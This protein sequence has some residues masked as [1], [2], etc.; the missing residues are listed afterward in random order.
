[1]SSH[2]QSSFN[3]IEAEKRLLDIEHRKKQLEFNQR[4]QEINRN[5]ALLQLRL[6]KKHKA[7]HTQQQPSR[8]H[9][10]LQTELQQSPSPQSLPQSSPQHAGPSAPHTTWVR[11]TE[12]Q[13]MVKESGIDDPK[14]KRKALALLINLRTSNPTRK[15]HNIREYARQLAL[16]PRENFD[17]GTRDHLKNI[18][19]MVSLYSTRKGVF[20]KNA[21]LSKYIEEH[22]K[23]HLSERAFAAIEKRRERSKKYGGPGA[24][25]TIAQQSTSA[26][27]DVPRA[28]TPASPTT[29]STTNQRAAR[30]LSSFLG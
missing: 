1:M 7:S 11:T 5:E 19:K 29:S 23:K 26:A 4:K 16:D 18:E 24:S 3:S 28:S 20:M 9:S 21:T 12:F 13:D 30:I 8:Q 25:A 15:L 22:T 10:L 27:P 6:R 14:G 17:E 2:S